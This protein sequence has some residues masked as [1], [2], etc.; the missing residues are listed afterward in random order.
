MQ[1]ARPCLPLEAAKR[2]Q[3]ARASC[4]ADPGCLKPGYHCMLVHA[5]PAVGGDIHGQFY[6][7]TELFKVGG[8]CPQVMS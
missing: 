2:G 3:H 7:L 4:H 8:D 6:D 5:P 1:A